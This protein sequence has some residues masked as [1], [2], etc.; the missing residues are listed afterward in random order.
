MIA[1]NVEQRSPEWLAWKCRGVGAS[2]SGSIA[3]AIGLLPQPAAWM[4]T[5]QE[6]WEHKV[7]LRPPKKMHPGMMRG[8]VYEEDAVAFH[9]AQTGLST[10]PI[11]GEMD[12][13]TFVQSSFDGVT[14]TDSFQIEVILET[15]VPN[16]EVMGLAGQGIVVPYYQPQCAHQCL[17]AWGHPDCWPQ[18]AE[19]HFVAFQPETNVGHLV[20]VRADQYK[21]LASELLPAIQSFWRN[22]EE[23]LPPCGD[24]WLQAA[25]RYRL[26]AV[27]LEQAK[28]MEEA[29]KEAL[30][31]AYPQGEVKTFSGGGVTVTKSSKAG[32]IQY[33]QYVKDQNVPA[34]ALEKYRGK[35]S[36]SVRITVNEKTP[37]PQ[38][39]DAVTLALK[40]SKRD[41]LL[42]A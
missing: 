14:F 28:A 30:L 36:S 19:H 33:A 23:K 18:G 8:T 41:L 38:L 6:L 15:K 1:I 10:T 20:V 22:V 27:A 2:E 4:D 42:A 37:M 29:A 7:G 39:S 25:I 40:E 31:A 13:H 32:S 26:A 21:K 24:A 12:G 35:E 9:K 34:E 17:A 5:I 11:C 16:E 3:A